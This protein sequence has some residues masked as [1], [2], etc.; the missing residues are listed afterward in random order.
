MMPIDTPFVLAGPFRRDSWQLII[1][2]PFVTW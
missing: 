1:E 2:L